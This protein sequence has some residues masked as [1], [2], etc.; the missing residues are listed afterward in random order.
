M[1]SD[2]AVTIA[3][4][5]YLTMRD[6]KITGYIGPD[7][8]NLFRAITLKFGLDLYV[9]TK[10]AVIPT[11]GLTITRMLKMATE[12]SGKE[13]KRGGAPLA[14]DDLE[15]WIDAMRAALPVHVT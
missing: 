1:P 5:S 14:I 9:A 7:A 3:D 13:Y 2:K 15:K 11:R 12:Y 6:G 8:A 4:Q 10:G